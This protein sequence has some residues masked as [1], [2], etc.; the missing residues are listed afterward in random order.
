MADL[1]E[2]LTAQ[3]DADTTQHPQESH[4][5][6]WGDY[7]IPYGGPCRAQRTIAA[8]RAIVAWCVEVIGDRDMSRYGEPGL[9]RDDKDALAVTMAMETLRS[10]ASIYELRDGFDP[11][12]KVET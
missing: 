3:L 9:L 7:W 1:V 11:S 6:E 5:C 10:L 8:H 4:R 12:W 2:W